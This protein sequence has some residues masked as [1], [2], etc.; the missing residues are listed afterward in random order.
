MKIDVPAGVGAPPLDTTTTCE[1]Q[2]QFDQVEDGCLNE[3]LLN[4]CVNLPGIMTSL[5][6][7]VA[8]IN[9]GMSILSLLK[10]CSEKLEHFYK[11]DQE[12]NT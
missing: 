3:S 10:V 9:E 6:G 8:A 2:S 4:K 11:Y 7:V 12:Y 1:M 5:V